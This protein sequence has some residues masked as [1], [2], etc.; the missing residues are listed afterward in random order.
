VL[1]KRLLDMRK[2]MILFISLLIL[3]ISTTAVHANELIEPK[4]LDNKTSTLVGWKQYFLEEGNS[5]KKIIMKDLYNEVPMISLN[6]GDNYVTVLPDSE[7]KAKPIKLVEYTRSGLA[8]FSGNGIKIVDQAGKQ[9]SLAYPNGAIF[10]GNDDNFYRFVRT[11]SDG[12]DVFFVM[13]G[14]FYLLSTQNKKITFLTSLKDFMDDVVYFTV[15]RRSDHD[16][17]LISVIESYGEPHLGFHGHSILIRG[18]KLVNYWS[19]GSYGG[20]GVLPAYLGEDQVVAAQ[21]GQLAVYSLPSLQSKKYPINIKEPG[22]VFANHDYVVL[23]SNEKNI[24]EILD[25][26]TGQMEEPY[27]AL[28][29]DAQKKI[30]EENGGI[31]QEGDSLQFN[32]VTGDEFV[33]EVE[34]VY[35]FEPPAGNVYDYS[36]APV[37]RYRYNYPTKEFKFE[38][39]ENVSHGLS[40]SPLING[41]GLNM[42]I[43]E[44]MENLTIYQGGE[45]ASSI[46]Y[47]RKYLGTS[48]TGQLRQTFFIEN[49][50]TGEKKESIFVIKTQNTANNSE[51][52]EKIKLPADCFNTILKEALSAVTYGNNTYLIT[53]NNIYKVSGAK[54]VKTIQ[55]SNIQYYSAGENKVYLFDQNNIYVL[56]TKTDQVKLLGKNPY[57]N[58]QM[59]HLNPIDQNEMTGEIKQIEDAYQ[60]TFKQGEI[61]ALLFPFAENYKYAEPVFN[62]GTKGY[63]LIMDN[64]VLKLSESLKNKSFF[65]YQSTAKEYSAQLKKYYNITVSMEGVDWEYTYRTEYPVAVT[66]TKAKMF[67]HN[68]EIKSA[69]YPVM[70]N[71]SLLIP[72][73]QTAGQIGL[74]FEFDQKNGVLTLK[75]GNLE[76][77]MTVNSNKASVNNEVVEMS[78]PVILMD[79]EVM[80]PLRFICEKFGFKNKLE[81]DYQNIS[82]TEGS[83]ISKV[84]ID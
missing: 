31:F 13:E 38:K 78:S 49:I 41:K 79:G 25:L 15:S 22:I 76:A 3:N 6:E 75:R 34:N 63:C 20:G 69:V 21:G 1:Y 5:K 35:R 54:I 23:K 72:I 64:S 83:R 81:Y 37:Y 19:N 59:N 32:S 18:D 44:T 67:Y 74:E 62:D 43:Q 56:D 11:V 48:L 33:F 84:Y 73:K 24:L 65:V 66:K 7:T 82:T 14:K 39:I 42:G 2:I 47:P 28:Y 61:D 17:K 53:E 4:I 40:E 60:K 52:Q 77:E 29:N 27:K 26:K 68:Q 50:K 12:E 58:T 55:V 57:P 36:K 10:T 45:I 51:K 8:N 71:G 30:V 16:S 46:P 9:V 70:Q 80:V